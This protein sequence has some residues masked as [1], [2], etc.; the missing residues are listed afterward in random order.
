M[1]RFTV[2]LCGTPCNISLVLNKADVVNK[3]I[4]S[5]GLFGRVSF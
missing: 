2:K 5:Q 1:S 4:I 3:R